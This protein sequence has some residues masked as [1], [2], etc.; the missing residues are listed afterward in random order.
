MET[1]ELKNAA[2]G[3]VQMMKDDVRSKLSQFLEETGITIRQMARDLDLNEDELDRILHG[4]GIVS[5]ET[6]ATLLI[7]NGL[8]LEVKPISEAPIPTHNGIPV[9]P[10]EGFVPRNGQMPPPPPGFFNRPS[11]SRRADA[12]AP[13]QQPR[14]SRG[15]F[16]PRT[17]SHGPV[18]HAARQAAQNGAPDFASMEREKL[19]DIIQ[20][21]LWDTEIDVNRASREEMVRFLEDKNRRL[22]DLQARKEAEN[23]PAVAELKEKIKNTLKSNP[24]LVNVI[25]QLIG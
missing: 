1:R 20:T 11:A 3:F 12:P 9:P 10:R 14:D 13:S 2:R 25:K 19:A 24:H 17:D 7:A 22:A 21:K 8:V 18:N 4:D 5:L 23:D 6:F 16:M 15:R